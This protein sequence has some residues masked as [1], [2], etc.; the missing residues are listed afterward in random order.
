MSKRKGGHLI[1]GQAPVNT[2]AGGKNDNWVGNCSPSLHA[3]PGCSGCY[4]FR[5]LPLQL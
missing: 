1:G 3:N 2:V 5:R 4:R